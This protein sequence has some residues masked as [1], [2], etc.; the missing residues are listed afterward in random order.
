[1]GQPWDR[2]TYRKIDDPELI[3]VMTGGRKY[4]GI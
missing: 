2:T 4:D 1:M 3:P